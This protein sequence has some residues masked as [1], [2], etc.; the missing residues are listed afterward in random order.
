MRAH[1]AVHCTA[2]R[3]GFGH[4]I[5]AWIVLVALAT[6]AAAPPRADAAPRRDWLDDV[7]DVVDDIEESLDDARDVVR[8]G[9]FATGDGMDA[10]LVLQHLDSAVA[11]VRGLLY[12]GPGPSLD[13]GI[14]I[15]I[16]TTAAPESLED[17]ARVTWKLAVQALDETL[18]GPDFDQAF[19]ASQL[20]TIEHLVTRSSP[21]SYTSRATGSG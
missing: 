17:Y 18:K 9:Q 12:G 8:A 10:Q 1:R 4:C 11:G 21:H 14:P 20:A 6:L 7:L 16:D 5:C 3:R 19:V 15:V 2:P 13:P